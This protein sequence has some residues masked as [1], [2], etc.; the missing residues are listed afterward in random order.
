MV[1][2]LG[3]VPERAWTVI[4]GL[5]GVVVLVVGYRWV[6][7]EHANFGVDLNGPPDGARSFARGTGSIYAGRANTYLPSSAVIWTSASPRCSPY[8]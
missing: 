8:C 2:R 6:H 7:H 1:G 3:R 4:G 5:V